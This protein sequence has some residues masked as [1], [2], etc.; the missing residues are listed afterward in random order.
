MS[1]DRET[2]PGLWPLTAVFLRI[3]NLTFGGGQ[4]TVAALQRELVE[5]RGWLSANSYGLSFALAR[6]TPGT[7]V[8]A[9]C[10]ATG[11]IMRGW[12]GAILA[13]LAACV[14]SAAI[15]AAMV[16]GSKAIDTNPWAKAMLAGAAAAVVGMMAANALQ[17]ASSQWK[18]G[19][20]VRT[21]VLAAAA[22]VASAVMHW[23]PVP[24]LIAAAAAGYLWREER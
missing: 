18:P 19:T 3:G 5:R 8:L 6:V 22:F 15:L 17:L 9:F 7:N 2:R 10:A 23:P 21:A 14:P 16:S 24:V 11:W 20:E 12:P 4:P 13:V 1:T